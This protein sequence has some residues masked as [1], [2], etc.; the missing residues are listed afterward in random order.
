[1]NIKDYKSTQTE[2][3]K[4]SKSDFEELKNSQEFKDI[5][6]EYGSVVEDFINNYASKSEPELIQDLL[7]L[8]AEKKKDGTFDAKKLRDL[9]EMIAPMLDDEMRAKMYNLLNFL[10]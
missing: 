2:E 8:I 4:T 1:M 5:E 6:R 3:E 7:R 9:A 10:D